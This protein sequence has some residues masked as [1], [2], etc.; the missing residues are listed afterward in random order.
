MK[1]MAILLLVMIVFLLECGN[2]SVKTGDSAPDFML[3]DGDGKRFY[4]NSAFGKVVLLNFWN[5]GCE[6]CRREI[7]LLEKLS[8]KINGNIMIIGIC[9]G[10]ADVGRVEELLKA[11]D[12]RYLNL[13]DS[14]NKVSRLYGIN[15][16]PVTFILDKNSVVRYKHSG[17]YPD[18]INKYEQEILFLMRDAESPK[19]GI[20]NEF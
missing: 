9:S 11:L 2:N 14:E 20:K 18:Y 15:S 17:F 6:P 16:V 12:A 8:K 10:E 4:L 19:T 1:T 3:Y 7:P 13:L 5:T